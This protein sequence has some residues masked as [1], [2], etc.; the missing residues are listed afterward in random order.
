MKVRVV[1]ACK[2][3]LYLQMNDEKYKCEI[4]KVKTKRKTPN[5]QF[6]NAFFAASLFI[7][8]LDIHIG[9]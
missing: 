1:H 5:T 4:Y 7:F 2:H 8:S 3:G 9:Y 6:P